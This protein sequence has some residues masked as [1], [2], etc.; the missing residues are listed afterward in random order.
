MKIAILISGS[1]RFS[2]ELDQFISNLTG[3]STVDWFVHTWAHNPR[4]D[5]LGYE[6]EILVAPTWRTVNKEWAIE[7]IKSN[8][9]VNHQ[10]I[11]LEIYDSNLLEYPIVTGP[12]VHHINF[13]SVWK[14]HTGW[15]KVDTMRQLHSTEYDIVIRSRPDLLLRNTLDLRNIKDTLDKNPKTILVSTGGQHG[16]GYNTNDIIGIASPAN[17]SIYTDVVNH[18]M[19]YNREGIMCHPETLLAYHLKQNGL[20]STPYINVDIRKSLTHNA[21][22]TSIVDFGRWQ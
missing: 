17:M 19:R 11:D 3:Y 5:K 7:K 22:G 18:S 8:L 13:P 20:T 14:M 2:S 12:Q 4:P 6:H 15:K 21:D 16:Y 1:P 9:P 10:L